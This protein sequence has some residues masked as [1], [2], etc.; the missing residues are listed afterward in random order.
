MVFHGLMRM[1]LIHLPRGS[2]SGRQCDGQGPTG[3]SGPQ[4]VQA[5]C[6]CGC[7]RTSTARH[8]GVR[9]PTE[10]KVCPLGLPPDLSWSRASCRKHSARSC[11][12]AR[13]RSGCGR[14]CGYRGRYDPT[15]AGPRCQGPSSTPHL[16]MQSFV[17][18][19]H[20]P[21]L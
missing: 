1:W 2:S 13:L 4:A 18:L 11:I 10:P 5:R 16:C 6:Q 8:Q 9:T 15:V 12:H 21:P 3:A 17:S 20:H 19:A 14:A 7:G